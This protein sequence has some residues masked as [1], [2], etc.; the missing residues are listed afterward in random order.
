MLFGAQLLVLKPLS[1][2]LLLSLRLLWVSLIGQSLISVRQLALVILDQQVQS[3]RSVASSLSTRV[4]CNPHNPDAV[5]L[6]KVVIL[7]LL[8][9]SPRD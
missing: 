9:N 5:E 2:L 3:S 1:L 8:R 6:P 4:S 7:V